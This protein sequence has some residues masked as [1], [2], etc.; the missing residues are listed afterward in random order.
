MLQTERIETK[1]INK[2]VRKEDLRRSTARIE[3]REKLIRGA[4]EKV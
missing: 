4:S 1:E 3:S 2:I